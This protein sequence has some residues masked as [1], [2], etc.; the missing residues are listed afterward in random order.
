MFSFVIAF[1]VSV[2]VRHHHLAQLMDRSHVGGAVTY[3]ALI[4]V[5]LARLADD[6]GSHDVNRHKACVWTVALIHWQFVLG[7]AWW[8][9][10]ICR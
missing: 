10:V 5:S 9:A 6:S 3:L 2:K 1:P 7:W 4:R 8:V